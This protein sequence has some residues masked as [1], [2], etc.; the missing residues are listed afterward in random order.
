[1]RPET[2]CRMF[3]ILAPILLLALIPSASL[4]QYSANVE[5][6]VTDSTGAVIPQVV[7][8][9]RSTGTGVAL[10]ATANSDGYYHFSAIAPG[11][12]FVVASMSGFRTETVAVTVTQDQRRGVNITLVPAASTVNVTVKE[13]APALN[14]EE[15]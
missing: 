15:T 1:M 7:V 5:G 2:R 4:A 13:V 11:D 8:T 10:K 3:L 14:P 9:L 6:T 12:Y